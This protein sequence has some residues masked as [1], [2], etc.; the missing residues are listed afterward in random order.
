[1]RLHG[2]AAAR[3]MGGALEGPPGMLTGMLT[4]VLTGVSIDS[5][6]LAP[7]DLFFAIRGPRHDGHAFVADAFR[8]GARGAVVGATTGTGQQPCRK[9]QRAVS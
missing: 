6:T 7:G 3:A 4:G 8:R 2:E 5:R 9:R 1:M